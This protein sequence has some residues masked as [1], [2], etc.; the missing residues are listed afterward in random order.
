MTGATPP[1]RVPFPL[2]RPGR[3]ARSPRRGTLCPSG[4]DASPAPDSLKPAEVESGG[5]G[6]GRDAPV[7]SGGRGPGGWG[8]VAARTRGHGRRTSSGADRDVPASPTRRHFAAECRPGMPEETDQSLEA[9]AGSRGPQVVRGRSARIRRHGSGRSAGVRFQGRRRT[10]MRRV[11][12]GA[13][14][15][16][17]IPHSGAS[18][19]SRPASEPASRCSVQT[20]FGTGGPARCLPHRDFVIAIDP[21]GR[22]IGQALVAAG[23]RPCLLPDAGDPRNTEP[24]GP[25]EADPKPAGSARAEHAPA[26]RRDAPCLGRGFANGTLRLHDSRVP[27][28]TPTRG[29]VYSDSQARSMNHPVFRV[30]PPG[31]HR[32]L[33]QGRAGLHV[34]SRRPV[35]PPPQPPAARQP[36]VPS[37]PHLHEEAKRGRVQ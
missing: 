7:R 8:S 23:R 27:A 11:E 33:A 29:D 30:A 31:R 1:L 24:A 3:R 32:R 28:A 16:R 18:R 21:S 9:L 13:A 25:E 19:L 5:S 17:Q 35:D 4:R 12:H 20:G 2:G 26:V 10:R 22:R 15:T 34:P 36:G 6:E 37:L 14:D